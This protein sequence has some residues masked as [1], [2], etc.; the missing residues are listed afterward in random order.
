[1]RAVF[2]RY[3]TVRDCAPAR[4]LRWFRTLALE[5]NSPGE[6]ISRIALRIHIRSTTV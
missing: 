6:V 1:M 3:M 2:C 5:T 4:L